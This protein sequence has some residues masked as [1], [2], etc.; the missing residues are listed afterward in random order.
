MQAAFLLPLIILFFYTTFV[1]FYMAKQRT[2]A[3]KN[4]EI[5]ITI[6]N[7][8]QQDFP[9]HLAIIDRH[10]KNLLELP[11]LFYIAALLLLNLEAISIFSILCSW[12]FCIMRLM[13][14]FVHL[15]G[16]NIKHRF[17][18]FAIGLL[19]LKLMWLCVFIALF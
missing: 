8:Y 5:N 18:T 3:I 19:F 2:Q 11:P 13:H 14:G 12:G 7:T 17:I 4:K 16:N 10:F 9:E 15:R 6:F 1:L